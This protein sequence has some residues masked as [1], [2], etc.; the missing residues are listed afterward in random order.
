MCPECGIPVADSLRGILLQ[1]AGAEYRRSVHT[2]LSLILYGILLLII[3]NFGAAFAGAILAPSTPS[4]LTGLFEAV[5]L[6]LT[7]ATYAMLCV[8]YW[9]FSRPDPGFEGTK[10]ASKS[11]AVLRISAVVMF[12]SIFVALVLDVAPLPSKIHEPVKGLAGLVMFVSGIIQFYATMFYVAWLGSRVPDMY[13]MR[14]AR[15]S[16]WLTPILMII[17]C[18]GWVLALVSYWNLL[19]RLRTHLAA[20]E[21]TGEPAILRPRDT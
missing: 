21:R 3:I 4:G 6:L 20:I 19:N 5:A 16:M 15:R 7:L 8:G 11:A 13:I 14:R 10:N 2:G 17:A 12:F 18:I 9:K 1:Y